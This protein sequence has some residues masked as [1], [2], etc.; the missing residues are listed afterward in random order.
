MQDWRRDKRAF[1]VLILPPS[2]WLVLFFTLPLAIV[3]VYSFGERGPLG[4]TLLALSFD[5]YGR[6]VEWINLSIIL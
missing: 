1:G 6:A 4:Q 3:W 5:N 2:A